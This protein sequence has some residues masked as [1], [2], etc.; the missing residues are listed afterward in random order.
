MLKKREYT[1]ILCLISV[2]YASITTIQDST[3]K[4]H[5]MHLRINPS[6]ILNQIQD[7]KVLM[8]KKY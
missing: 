6:E 3:C 8:T 5:V 2:F 7:G 4:E 1:G